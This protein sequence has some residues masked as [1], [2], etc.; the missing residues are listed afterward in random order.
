LEESESDEDS[1]EEESDIW[2]DNQYP[3][4][5]CLRCDK[6]LNSSTVVF[7]GGGGDCE[8]WYCYDCHADGTYDCVVCAE[9]NKGAKIRKPRVVKAASPADSAASAS[10]STKSPAKRVKIPFAA[11][12]KA[13]ERA[14]RAFELA[15]HKFQAALLARDEAYATQLLAQQALN[16]MQQQQ[17]PV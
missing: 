11:Q 9:M 5:S 10:S 8:T 1:D 3:N 17:S 15:N 12:I 6:K 7:C 16:A 2:F 13:V 14:K 4:A